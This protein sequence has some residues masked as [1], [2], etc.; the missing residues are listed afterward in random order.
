MCIAAGWNCT[1]PAVRTAEGTGEGMARQPDEIPPQ[2]EVPPP[3]P[4]TGRMLTEKQKAEEIAKKD[5][6]LVYSGIL[7][8]ICL[9]AAV[10]F[11]FLEKWRKRT[12]TDDGERESSTS[13]SNYRELYENGEI[14]EAEY[15]KIRDRIAAQMKQ[16]LGLPQRPTPKPDAGPADP[17][18]LPSPDNPT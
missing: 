3:P 4:T 5:E 14:T 16:K 18:A 7:I 8:A 13:L 17:Q 11:L 12:A 10:V 9:A 15:V 6:F 2:N 1:H